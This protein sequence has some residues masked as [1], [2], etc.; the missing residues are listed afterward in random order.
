M[1]LD[2]LDLSL[3]RAVK[4]GDTLPVYSRALPTFKAPYTHLIELH[5]KKT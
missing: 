4:L 3:F 1:L 5:N 2:R